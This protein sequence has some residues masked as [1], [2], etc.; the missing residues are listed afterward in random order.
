M[1]TQPTGFFNYLTD[2]VSSASS[3]VG[4]VAS[5]VSNSTVDVY[6]F[7]SSHI[8]FLLTYNI[9]N[10]TI[11]DIQSIIIIFSDYYLINRYV[12]PEIK[13]KFSSKIINLN[14]II[15][16]HFFLKKYKNNSVIDAVK[17]R[18]DINS[19]LSSAILFLS[20]L[21]S[22][23]HESS[24]ID[25]NK[26][27]SSTSTDDV[28]FTAPEVSVKPSNCVKIQLDKNIKLVNLIEKTEL[29]IQRT[30]DEILIKIIENIFT[31]LDNIIKYPDKY[32]AECSNIKLGGS[33]NNRKKI[34]K[35]KIT[36][37]RKII[38]KKTVKHLH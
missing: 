13:K 38:R 6:Q 28:G 15:M 24:S 10:F 30:S 32:G 33:K 9:Y 29:V 2:A 7:A 36:K 23:S 21:N 26:R 12:V 35:S 17:L 34:R 11:D 19:V 14:K 22:D 37:R 31:L 27:T 4:S 3:G 16:I 5:T 1:E 8:P 20:T 18:N 25:F